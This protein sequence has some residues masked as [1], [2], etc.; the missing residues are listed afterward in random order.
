MLM[1]STEGWLICLAGIKYLA[2]V[3]CLVCCFCLSACRSAVPATSSQSNYEWSADAENERVQ[4]SGSQTNM[5]DLTQSYW[6]A[7][8]GKGYGKQIAGAAIQNKQRVLVARVNCYFFRPFFVQKTIVISC[9][10]HTI[11]V[12]KTEQVVGL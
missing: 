9:I 12:Q 7:M 3:L 11:F 8:Q 5:V 10:F 2:A 6:L 4:I 1:Y